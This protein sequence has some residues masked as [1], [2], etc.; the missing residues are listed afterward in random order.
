MSD[1]PAAGVT[2]RRTD[3]ADIGQR[4]V[5]VR[6][7]D[8]PRATLSFGDSVTHALPP[9][10]HVLH[11]HNTLVWK[12]VPFTVAAGEQAEFQVVNKPGR[13]TLGFL[14]LMGVA[15]LFLT[16]HRLASSSGGSDPA[17]QGSS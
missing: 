3:R 8:G 11:A 16:I 15:P 4:Q 12:R 10:D 9:G 6:V 2:I 5:I 13:F 7:D 17:G 1:A 14:S